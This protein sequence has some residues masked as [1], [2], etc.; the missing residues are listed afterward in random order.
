MEG[1]GPE[2]CK[3]RRLIPPGSDLSR[4]QVEVVRFTA[5]RSDKA[6]CLLG[7]PTPRSDP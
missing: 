5:R 3:I 2:A 4:S 7:C 6:G 1:G